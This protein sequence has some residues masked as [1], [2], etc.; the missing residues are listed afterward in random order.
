MTLED[1]KALFRLDGRV[2]L[3]AGAASGIG[4]AS[5]HGLAAAGAVTIC[6]DLNEDGA[7]VT[8]RE[9]REH[10]GAAESLAARYHGPSDSAAPPC[11]RISRAAAAAVFV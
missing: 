7:A 3:V 9:I 1:F 10:G 8:A 11:S 2:A 6:A 5:A 4:K